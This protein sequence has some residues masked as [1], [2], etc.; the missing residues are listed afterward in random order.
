MT[1]TESVKWA[2]LG[3]LIGRLPL[4][5]RHY[6]YHHVLLLTWTCHVIFVV[7]GNQKQVLCLN[8]RKHT[9]FDKV[10]PSESAYKEIETGIARALVL[11]FYPCSYK[12]AFT[13]QT[14]AKYKLVCVNFTEKKKTTK[15]KKKEQF[16]NDFVA[17]LC[18]QVFAV[19][20][21]YSIKKENK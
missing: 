5:V 21:V 17:K 12:A 7:R 6:P 19:H 3:S 13:L 16:G 18:P 14:V 2:K 20:Y 10:I 9:A 4:P 1:A 15:T 11:S 8:Y